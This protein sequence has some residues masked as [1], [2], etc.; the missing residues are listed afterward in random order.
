MGDE[1]DNLDNTEITYLPENSSPILLPAPSRT[2]RRSWK[3]VMTSEDGSSNNVSGARGLQTFEGDM[4]ETMTASVEDARWIFVCSM[5]GDE[6]EFWKELVEHF[7]MRTL[8]GEKFT[9]VVLKRREDED[10]D[11]G[12]M[13]WEREEELRWYHQFYPVGKGLHLGVVDPRTGERLIVFEGN[14]GKRDLEVDVVLTELKEFV[15]RHS[16][17]GLGP[18]HFEKKSRQISTIRQHKTRSEQRDCFV[19]E[20]EERAIA[21]AIEASL[22]ESGNLSDAGDDGV[23]LFGS[24]M[25]SF[26]STSSF[27]RQVSICESSANEELEKN[28]ELRWEQDEEFLN[29]LRKDMAMEEE[30]TKADRVRA[31]A[32]KRL[33]REASCDDPNSIVVVVRLPSGERLQYRFEGDCRWRSVADLVES[34][35]GEKFKDSALSTAQWGLRTMYDPTSLNDWEL[36]LKNMRVGK[37]FVVLAT[38]LST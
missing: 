3:D 20:D 28:R 18:R 19:I 23:D 6:D 27:Q 7:E 5:L 15:K 10:S 35:T 30:T 1:N 37:S 17:K 33:P 4:E 31:E 34:K 32:R 8:L 26:T 11:G 22:I 16:L 25:D 21:A 14:D 2:T 36:Q 38:R 24:S 13:E 29:A 12:L 9:V